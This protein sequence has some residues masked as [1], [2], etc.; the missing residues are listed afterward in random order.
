MVSYFEGIPSKVIKHEKVEMMDYITS[1]IVDVWN[2]SPGQQ[3]WADAKYHL[4][5][6]K[7]L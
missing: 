7:G 3:D 5:K 6:R 1:L 2:G 4:T